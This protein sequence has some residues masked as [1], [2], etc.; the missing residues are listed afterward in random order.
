MSKARYLITP[1]GRIFC[2]A[3]GVVSLVNPSASWPFFQVILSITPD[4]VLEKAVA[5][6]TNV[7]FKK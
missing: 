6:I 4:R 2:I 1:N 3:G 7:K 5:E